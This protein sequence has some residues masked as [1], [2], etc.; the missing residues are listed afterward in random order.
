MKAEIEVGPQID[1]DGTTNPMRQE[2]LGAL[3]TAELHGKYAEQTVRGNVYTAVSASAALVANAATTISVLALYN[4]PGSGK[5]LY[6]IRTHLLPTVAPGTQVTGAFAY[7]F[8]NNPILSG[9]I[10][11]VTVNSSLIGAN[12]RGVGLAY[13]VAT[14]SPAPAVL[15]PLATKF[16]VS[17][18]TSTF[19]VRIVDDV[20][21]Q[22]VIGPGGFLTVQETTADTT[23][24]YSAVIS[25]VWEEVPV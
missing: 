10:T 7:Y 18:P 25:F 8:V 12:Q 24:N 1:S 15:L 22:I 6:L 14:I 17:A 11:A 2:R 3:I 13:S 9:T 20:D 19:P 16:G 23:T 5:N 4:P 21:G